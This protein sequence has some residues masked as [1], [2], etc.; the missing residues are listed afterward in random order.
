MGSARVSLRMVG[1]GLALSFLLPLINI[2]QASLMTRI[3]LRLGG[4]HNSVSHQVGTHR[5]RV[6]WAVRI[7]REEE[8]EEWGKKDKERVRARV[9]EQEEGEGSKACVGICYYNKLVAL[10][11][12]EDLTRHN[13][14]YKQNVVPDVVC[15]GGKCGFSEDGKDP[16]EESRRREV[17]EAVTGSAEGDVEGE[18]P[19]IYIDDAVDE[20]EEEEKAETSH[21]ASP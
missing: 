2:S 6:P 13:E 18:G 7:Q 11:A 14:V 3:G 4:K 19:D 10:E 5:S 9:A 21:P 17:N 1:R 12:K 8:Q 15:P 20:E 16:V